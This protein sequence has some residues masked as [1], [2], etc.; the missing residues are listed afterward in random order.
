MSRLRDDPLEQGLAH[1]ILG[2]RRVG[3]LSRVRYLPRQRVV[4]KAIG[5][6]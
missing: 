5:S 6:D 1:A 2:E 4:R 3:D